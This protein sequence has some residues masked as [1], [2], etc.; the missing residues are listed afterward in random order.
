M[1]DCQA[2]ILHLTGIADEAMDR[3]DQRHRHARNLDRAVSAAERPAYVAAAG[4]DP[5]AFALAL[6]ALRDAV[7]AAEGFSPR[8]QA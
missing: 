4:D 8:E 1:S 5:E 6:S 3:A 7:R 2:K